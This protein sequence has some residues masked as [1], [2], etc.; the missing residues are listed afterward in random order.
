MDRKINASVDMFSCFLVSFRQKN[1][2]CVLV[3]VHE[4]AKIRK[5]LCK[6]YVNTLKSPNILWL[7]ANVS[8]CSHHPCWYNVYVLLP[9]A[10]ICHQFKATHNTTRY[11]PYLR[12]RH[13]KKSICVHE[14]N[15]CALRLIMG[16]DDPMVFIFTWLFLLQEYLI[17][18][19]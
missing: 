7:F 19:R 1:V 3:D 17:K 4:M 18:D 6:Q 9:R 11:A 16:Q 14:M 13:G 10:D 2:F 5:F 15:I 8:D 12:W